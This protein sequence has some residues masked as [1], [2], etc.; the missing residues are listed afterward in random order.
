MTDQ[1]ELRNLVQQSSLH[2]TLLLVA[3]ALSRSGYGDIEILDRR[4]PRQKSRYGGCELLCRSSFANVPVRIIVKVIR[5]SVRIRML[6]EMAGAIDR[7]KAD[8]GIVVSTADLSQKARAIRQTYRKSR[9]EV[10]DLELLTDMLSRYKIG[11]RPGGSPDYA[12]FSSLDDH[13]RRIN[14]FFSYEHGAR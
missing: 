10:I 9:V 3:K 8:F 1:A 14:A 2:A 6:D 7:T 4:E 13:I 5:D 11:V 12:Y